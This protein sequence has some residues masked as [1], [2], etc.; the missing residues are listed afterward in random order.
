MPST[1]RHELSQLGF[2]FKGGVIV[3]EEGVGTQSAAGRATRYIKAADPLL[4]QRFSN[5]S[6]FMDIP[7]VF[8]RDGKAVYFPH[9]TRIK[10]ARLIKVMLN[11]ESY[12]KGGEALPY[13]GDN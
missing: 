11:P 12:I 9:V 8:A 5:G 10:G 6:T 7:R 1:I 13:P 2:D 4:D 3:T